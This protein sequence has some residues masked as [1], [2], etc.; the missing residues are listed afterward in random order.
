M[1]TTSTNSVN[2]SSGRVSGL[3]S[4]INWNEMIDATVKAEE[5]R[6]VTPY[7][8]QI[9]RRAKEREAWKNLS[10]LVNTLSESARV[11]RRT[12]MGGF[13][14]T[15]PPSPSTSRSLFS[16]S[17]GLGAQAGTSN[18]EVVQLAETAK[19]AGGTVADVGAARGLAGTLTI[20]GTG[21]SIAATDSLRDIQ[22]KINDANTGASPTGVQAVIQSEGGTAGR[23]VLSRSAPG[24]GELTI[25]DSSGGV[26]RELGLVDTRSKPISSATLSAA[27]ALGLTP[28]IN[29]T[30]IRVGDKVLTVDL[31]TESISSI[32][33][34]I[35]AAGGSA[36]VE[37][38]AFGD[39]TRY[40][41]V[42]DGPVNAVSGDADSEAVVA[43]LGFAAG[44]AAGIRQTIQSG[45][46]TSSGNATATASTALAGLKVD[47]VSAN[48]SA[49]DAINIRGMRG[50]GTAVNFGLVIQAGDT[51]QT[52][53]DRLNDSTSG[54][55]A[56]AR[57]AVAQLGDDGR[58]RLTDGTAGTSRLSLSLGIS[59][60]DGTTGTLGTS[61]T[62]VS[63]RNREVQAGRDAIV[64]I[65]GREITR[66]SN[67]ISDAIFGV[68]LNLQ[69]A[70]PGTQVALTVRQD[71][72]ATTK[73]VEKLAESY[74]AVRLFFEEQRA[75][76]APLYGNS[77]LRRVMSS[78]TNALRTEVAGNGTYGRLPTVGMT[79][80]RYGA[81]ELDP[82]AFRTALGAKPSEVEALF[83]FG[84]VGDALISA[85]DGAT[86]FG[87]G[88][89]SNQM[90]NI[91]S[92]T[93]SLRSK[94]TRAQQRVE[95]RRL[96]LVD[97]FS[98][99]E[100]ALAKLKEQ[101]SMFTNL[102]G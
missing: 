96:Q 7:S 76:D 15:V 95:T 49:G 17:T 102:N 5:A 72:E 42:V 69:N 11:V 101:G 87:S 65:D 93:L 27:A 60:A 52:L 66:T 19:V 31:S 99:M 18:I 68:T 67:T 48:L 62:A 53:L 3:S 22:I 89:I 33:N 41:L 88:T 74:N 77:D 21:I 45:A 32:A 44:Q 97:Q 38:E 13:T 1:A 59:R 51:V 78:F 91:D 46:L 28:G 39:E 94:E 81:L 55:G 100:N 24:A 30:N 12:G 34:K 80:D 8:D 16:A 14:A 50:D 83:G 23:L 90:R 26:S 79:L 86:S 25:S 98:R 37:A 40:R 75:T 29:P 61:T 63:G 6:L 36:G 20:N 2:V 47:G 85:A 43:A 71:V 54:F 73:A 56:G 10:G 57:P 35:N 9:A 92:V 82:V 4:S 58:I 70:E 84:G 64:R